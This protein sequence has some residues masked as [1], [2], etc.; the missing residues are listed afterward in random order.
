MKEF[1]AVDERLEVRTPPGKEG[2]SGSRCG[3]PMD[4]EFTLD[5]NAS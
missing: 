2:G 4:V 3:V 5:S 1:R